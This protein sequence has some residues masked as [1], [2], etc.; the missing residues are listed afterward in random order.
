[1][2]HNLAQAFGEGAGAATIEVCRVADFGVDGR[3]LYL[4]GELQDVDYD[5]NGV[6]RTAK[7]HLNVLPKA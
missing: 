7:V 1:M 3:N 6:F 5:A 4:E 2:A